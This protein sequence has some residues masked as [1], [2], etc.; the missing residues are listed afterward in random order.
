MY[1]DQGIY[2]LYNFWSKK[3]STHLLKVVPNIGIEHRVAG[4]TLRI[5]LGG[6]S[7]NDAT[8]QFSNRD[9]NLTLVSHGT[10]VGNLN[11]DYMGRIQLTSSSFELRNVNVSDEGTYILRDNLNRKLK[12]VTMVLVDHHEGVSAGPFMGLLM[13][14][15]IPP[16]IFCCCRKKICKKNNQPTTTVNTPTATVNFDNQ[17]NPPG[18]PPAYPNI[19]APA[20]PSSAYTPGYPAIGGNVVHPPPNPTFPNQPPYSGYAMPPNPAS[21]PVYPPASGFP[22]AQPPQWSGAPYNPPAPA[23]IAPVMYS[24]PA[25]PEPVNGEINP[26]TP[27]LIPPQ[28]L[29]SQ[30]SGPYSGANVPNSSD[31]AVQFN[32]NMGKDSSL[33]FL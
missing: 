32:V 7:K 23:G 11:A 28:P 6:L 12:I 22:P 33:N 2:T 29:V 8:L 30:P 19:V 17:I 18:P 3:I 9:Y 20:D 4:E 25:G 31:S 13:L 27:L 1:D 26:T 14:L 24:A 10:P 5:S 15:G 21:N 16:C